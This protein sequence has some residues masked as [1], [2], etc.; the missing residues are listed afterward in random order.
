MKVPILKTKDKVTFVIG[1]SL[2]MLT[3]YI[4]IAEPQW[5]WLLYL[6]LLYPLMIHRFLTYHKI[7]HHY[8]ML[9]FCYYMQLWTLI[10]LFAFPKDISLFKVYF[11]LCNGP[12]LTAIVAWRNK[13]VF[14]DLDKITS[15]FIHL[16]PGLLTYTIRWHTDLYNNTNTE[17]DLKLMPFEIGYMLLFYVIWQALYVFKTEYLDANKFRNDSTLMSSARW[18]SSVQPHPIYKAVLKRGLNVSPTLILALI[19]LIYTIFTIIPVLFMYQYKWLHLMGILLIF[20]VSV[21]GGASFYF[22]SFTDNYTKRLEDKIK[23]FYDKNQD[24]LNKKQYLPTVKSV[25][26]FLGFFSFALLVLLTVLRLTV[27]WK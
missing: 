13:L 15:L 19:Q 14:H 17:E 25:A 12:L 3:E 9:D 26:A 18:L 20:G 23:K 11:G 1:I 8:F 7:N 27:L 24:S 5:L 10:V 6:F 22:E 16:F 21:W 4:L 2:L